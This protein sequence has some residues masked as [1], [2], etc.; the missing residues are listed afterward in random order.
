M[1]NTSHIVGVGKSIKVF[2]GVECT[3]VL[4]GKCPVL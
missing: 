1:H 2:V 4:S 3:L